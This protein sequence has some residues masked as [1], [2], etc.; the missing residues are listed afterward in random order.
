MAQCEKAEHTSQPLGALAQP[1]SGAVEQYA[2]GPHA[3][4]KVG[5]NAQSTGGDRS[6]GGGA[7]GGSC[8]MGSSPVSRNGSV[9]LPTL[10]LFSNMS[11]STSISL[12]P[13]TEN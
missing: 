13:P 8:E 5:T 1:A 2:Y 10:A 7:D 9:T 11:V 12:P 6:G 3:S 4:Q